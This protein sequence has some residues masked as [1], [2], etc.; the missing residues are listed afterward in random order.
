MQLLVSAAWISL[1]VTMGTAFWVTNSV[2]AS[3]T[4]PTALMKWTVE[5]VGAPG[6]YWVLISD[7]GHV[8]GRSSLQSFWLRLQPLSATGRT[9][10]SVAAASASRW[11]KCATR[12][13]IVRTGATSRWRSAVSSGGNL[14]LDQ[15]KEPSAGVSC[16]S[17]FVLQIWTSVCW[18]MAAALTS[19]RT[20]WS[21]SSVTAR[22]DCSSSITR[23]A[24]V[25]CFTWTLN[26]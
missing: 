21:A 16:C 23:P 22:L 4:A 19:V 3:E 24:E 2:M 13:E 26:L 17:V 5:T 18:T 8:D 9:S 10:S 15:N 1:N 14:V 7:W 12:S 20:W 25:C 6:F 11:A